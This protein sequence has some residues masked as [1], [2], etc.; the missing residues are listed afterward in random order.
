M[1][2]MHGIS[3][4]YGHTPVLNDFSLHMK[5]GEA[6]CLSGPSGSG[7]SSLLHLAADLI[8]PAKG[9]CH[10]ATDKIG[11]AFQEPPLLPWMTI[12]ENL[13]FIAGRGDMVH[14]GEIPLGWL[15]KMGLGEAAGCMPAE[16]S[17]GMKK[18]AGIACALA[19]QADLI[20][21]DEPFA[22]LD[23]AWQTRVAACVMDHVTSLGLT[24]LMVS[25][26]LEPLD[27]FGL[28]TVSVPEAKEP[29]M[30]HAV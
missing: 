2:K 20:L 29:L 7:K 10:V 9:T 15:E 25:H 18:R 14:A 21:L 28:R 6:V 24:L 3:I 30:R 19:A 1:I 27:G 17:G 16:L 22:G 5:P 4:G 26:Q 23:P 11:Y 13:L 8:K 12:R